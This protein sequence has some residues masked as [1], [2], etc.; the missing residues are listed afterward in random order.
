MDSRRRS[1]QIGFGE[2]GEI[3]RAGQ[4]EGL[5]IVGID[6]KHNAVGSFEHLLCT[7]LHLTIDVGLR[8]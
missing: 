5:G 8:V 6:H 4:V 7:L 2:D 1:G 3:G